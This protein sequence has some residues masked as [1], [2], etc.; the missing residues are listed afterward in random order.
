MIKDS[1]LDPKW[2]HEQ[3]TKNPPSVRPNGNIFSG[4]VRLSFANIFKIGKPGTDGGEGKFGTALL[5]P[6]ETDMAVF[7]KAWTDAA[8]SAFPNNWEPNGDPVGLHLPFHN[9]ADKAYGAKPLAGYTPGGMTFNVSSKFKPLVVDINQNLVV[10][11]TKI[12]AGVW[13]FVSLNVYSYGVSPPRPKKGIAFGLR[14]VMILADDTKLAGGGAD[15]SKDFGDVQ[16]TA[17]SNIAAKFDGLSG[18]SASSTAASLMPAGGHVGRQGHLPVQA[19]PS[20][21]IDPEL[22]AMM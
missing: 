21:D 9:Q 22:A 1:K 20:G 18:A 13:C 12:Y 7:S 16:I 17:Q 19:L 2:L 6:P 8:R 5:F 11:E 4:P 3:M 10:D 14:S 15:P